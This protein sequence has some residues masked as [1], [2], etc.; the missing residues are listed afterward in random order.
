MINMV[1]KKELKKE[2]NYLCDYCDYWFRGTKRDRRCI[3]CGGSK[4]KLVESDIVPK[5]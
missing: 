3:S 1:I 4:I 5:K 2:Y